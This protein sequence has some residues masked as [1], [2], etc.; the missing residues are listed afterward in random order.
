MRLPADSGRAAFKPGSNSSPGLRHAG[1]CILILLLTAAHLH[2][3]AIRHAGSVE[4]TPARATF[5]LQV[6]SDVAA[7]AALDLDLLTPDSR[8]AGGAKIHTRLERGTN[9]VDA[10][11]PYDAQVA[12]DLIFLRLRYGIQAGAANP[13]DGIVAISEFA[14]N[15]FHLA[16]DLPSSLPLAAQQPITVRAIQPATGAPVPGVV[17]RTP[18]SANLATTDE[19]GRATLTVATNDGRRPFRIVIEGER[20][21]LK[22][23]TTAQTWYERR[24]RNLLRLDRELY[25]PGQTVRMRAVAFGVDGR[26]APAEQGTLHVEPR[27]GGDN[28]FERAVKT[29]RFG[30]AAAEWEIPETTKPDQ[31]T[32]VFQTATGEETATFRVA[33][34]ELPLFRVEAAIRPGG[35]IRHPVIE[36]RAVRL[37]GEPI[38]AAEVTATAKADESLRVTSQT[39]ATGRASLALSRDEDGAFNAI[40][41]VTDPVSGRQEQTTLWMPSPDFAIEIYSHDRSSAAAETGLL[42]VET[43]YRSKPAPQCRVEARQGSR[44]VATGETNRFG[45]A[46]LEGR[47]EPGPVELTARD[48]RGFKGSNSSLLERPADLSIRIG[49]TLLAPGQTI[50]ALVRSSVPDDLV[51]IRTEGEHPPYV[52]HQ[53]LQLS[54]GRAELRI[55]YEPWFGARVF[56]YAGRVRSG[57]HRQSAETAVAVYYPAYRDLAVQVRL[58]KSE[59]RPGEK[60]RAAI[61]VQNPD[62][63]PTEAAIGLAAVDTASEE[64][65]RSHRT[66]EE[67]DLQREIWLEIAAAKGRYSEDLQLAAAVGLRESIPYFRREPD[68]PIAGTHRAF[69]KAFSEVAKDVESIVDRYR[70]ATLTSIRNNADFE[71][72]LAHAGQPRPVDPWGTPYAVSVGEGAGVL[73][74][75]AGP[76]G[77]H[78]TADDIEAARIA[79]TYWRPESRRLRNLLETL[80]HFPQ[81]ESDLR[82]ELRKQNLESI[83]DGPDGKPLRVVF[84]LRTVATFDVEEFSFEAYTAST[85]GRSR[86]ASQT[87]LVPTL[88]VETAHYTL[89]EFSASANQAWREIAAGASPARPRPGAGAIAGRVTDATEATIPNAEIELT[90]GRRTWKAKTNSGGAFRFPDLPAGSYRIAFQSPGFRILVV[91]AAPV[92]AGKVTELHAQLEVGSVSE[93]VSVQAKPPEPQYSTSSASGNPET[94]LRTTFPETL[95]WMPLLETD[96]NGRAEVE[97][98]VADSIT[99]WSLSAYGSTVTGATG[100]FNGAFRVT[101]PLFLELNPPPVL[102]TGDKITLPLTV[103]SGLSERQT[104]GVEMPG[105]GIQRVTVAANG[106]AQVTFRTKAAETFTAKATGGGES[107]AIRREVRLAPFGREA[108]VT[109]GHFLRGASTV[110][111]TVPSDVD[112][113]TIEGEITIYPNAFANIWDARHRLLSIPTGCAEQTIS[114]TYPNL[115]LLEY[116]ASSAEDDP[117]LR[118]QAIRNIQRG[119]DRLLGY[120]SGGGIGYFSGRG[121]DAPLTALAIEFLR[122]A[123]TY[124]SMPRELIDGLTDWLAGQSDAE[125]D[126]SGYIARVL[127]KPRTSPAADDPYAIAQFLLSDPAPEHSSRLI[128]R[129]AE[130]QTASGTWT[131]SNSLPLHSWGRAGEVEV[132]ALAVHAL[133]ITS[134]SGVPVDRALIDRALGA[135]VDLRGR[136]GIWYNT[137]ATLQVLRALR[138]ASIGQ[139]SGSARPIHRTL[140]GLRPGV[141]TIAIPEAAGHAAASVF[142]QL[143]YWEPWTT[144]QA[145]ETD[146]LGMRVTF[147]RTTVK[148]G[149]S[150]RCSLRIHRKAQRDNGMLIAEIGLPPG[151]EPDRDELDHLDHVSRYELTPGRVVFY[152]WPSPGQT[153]DLNFGVVLRYPMHAHALPSTLWDYANPDARVDV[154]PTGFTVQ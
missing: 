94:H 92:L 75:S 102:T 95:L 117:A 111:V 57:N 81:D 20:G 135:L 87:K 93:A 153:V 126:V 24:S 89:A 114:S 32:A 19:N 88:S 39:D 11:I 35:D 118:E 142:T 70:E 16:V 129:L 134:A 80:T 14:S 58:D 54:N 52:R 27:S 77:R 56:M 21:L 152:L 44:L 73:L 62:G 18:G 76:D 74:L 71:S 121:P 4:F 105:A 68:L 133:A 97:F 29:S 144:D 67:P 103:R 143:R 10:D 12:G 127:R 5:H 43:R 30:I 46:R 90:D 59:Y 64:A 138:A 66:F 3:Q 130:L 47:F 60:A 48:P 110:D 151:A 85:F 147:D 131:S 145:G 96:A 123:A 99:T 37:T 25:Q 7:T 120:R 1:K 42:T 150:V 79:Q 72:A 34:Y 149:G 86:M 8:V 112:P 113:A 84:A 26:P 33:L 115:L 53:I 148:A 36:V 139:L 82:R 106:A 13:T 124:A 78:G 100:E 91:H 9:V 107:D 137:Q 154:R 132:T 23:Q 136:N 125:T 6:Q 63:T 17:L 69:S 83:L 61:L 55:P 38:P 31:Y 140:A 40:V 65:A 128:A 50:E 104:V 45:I 49:K 22:T 116:L 122:D 108:V 119:V 101:Q 51:E 98:P 28:V 146:L 109:R 41:R 141:N 2:A 15:L